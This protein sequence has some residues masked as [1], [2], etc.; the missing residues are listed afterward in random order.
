MPGAMS[1]I[2]PNSP[3]VRAL[4]E[5][6][7]NGVFATMLKNAWA[8]TG[9]SA[10]SNNLVG[11]N[12]AGGMMSAP[13][14]IPSTTNPG[15]GR[16]TGANGNSIAGPLITAT[17]TGQFGGDGNTSFSFS[18]G[19]Q[20]ANNNNG[21]FSSGSIASFAAGGMMTEQGTAIRPGEMMGNTTPAAG[22]GRTLP[23]ARFKVDAQ[24]PT[25]PPMQRPTEPQ[26]GAT[27][28]AELTPQMIDQ[29]ATR[30]VQQNPQEAQK[31]Q[32]LIALAM[33]TGDL[34]PQE[35][36]TAIQLAKT[37]LANPS[38]Y[39]QVRQYA[40]QNGLGTEQDIP[41]QMDKGLLYILIVVGKA[42]QA[43]G[44][45]GN[46]MQGQGP[47][48]TMENGVLPEYKNGGMTGDTPHLAKV[49]PRE[50]VIPEDTLIYHGKKHFD[51]LVEQARTPP[52]AGGQ[53]K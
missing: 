39:P 20:G 34:T 36:N 23:S 13:T 4:M 26:L 6:N 27:P 40:I 48:P 15:L 1:L 18:G 2:D 32:A 12:N 16:Y 52:D 46:A 8:K 45:Q 28:D 31:V 38:S 21:N 53:Q 44:P 51:K 50:Y 41:Q 10:A 3:Q 19:D 14:G 35:L 25:M 30:F 5:R 24:A 49:H 9:T 33:Q 29:E 22:T 17:R 11:S 43:V 37:A 7:P 42:A 47:A